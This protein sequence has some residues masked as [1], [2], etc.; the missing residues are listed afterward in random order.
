MRLNSDDNEI[1]PDAGVPVRSSEI[2]RDDPEGTSAGG[3]CTALLQKKATMEECTHSTGE[4]ANTQI[5]V[6]KI[7]HHSKKQEGNPVC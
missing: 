1:N 2:Q 7:E 5:T 4:S 3:P 6:R